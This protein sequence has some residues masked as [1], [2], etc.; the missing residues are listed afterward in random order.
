VSLEKN[1][2]D[3]GT[4]F[5]TLAKWYSNSL[6]LSL[7]RLNIIVDPVSLEVPSFE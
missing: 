7:L 2:G 5:V 3:K 1:D 6:V 4:V